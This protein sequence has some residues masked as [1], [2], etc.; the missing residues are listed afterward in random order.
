METLS[1]FNTQGEDGM[2]FLGG[3]ISGQ[4]DERSSSGQS[5]VT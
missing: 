4:T 5:I 3:L 2:G 1:L